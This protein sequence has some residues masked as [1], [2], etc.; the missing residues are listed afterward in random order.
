M[1]QALA[2]AALVTGI[3][4]TTTGSY[5]DDHETNDQ[6]TTEEQKIG[7]SFGQMFGR[8]LSTTMT[9]I[10]I[11]SFVQGILDVYGNQPS[12]LTEQEI[13]QAMQVYQQQQQQKQMQ[14]QQE[15]ATVNLEKG[16]AFLADNA[17]KEGVITTDSGLQYK[18][19]A[20]GEGD[21][22]ALT[23]I[24][25]VH[26]TGTLLNGDVFDS[27]VERGKA[28]SFPVNGVIAGWIE[29]LQL[30]KPG[31]KWQLFIPANLAY[32]PMGN[33]RIGPNETLIFEVE[34]LAVK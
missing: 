14:Q 25:E 12:K 7:Y 15:L 23:D 18:I 3:L 33:G 28:A 26:Y 31:G 29:A 6:L 13:A 8:R 32:G 19:L 11:Q 16:T 2:L 1:K 22:P 9:D 30:M 17:A 4:L 20:K 27:S 34:L 21:S 24:V 10:D 5:A